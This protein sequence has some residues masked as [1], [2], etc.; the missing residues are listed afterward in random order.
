MGQARA[1]FAAEFRVDL[2]LRR[3]LGDLYRKERKDLE[4]LLSANADGVSAPGLAVLRQRS[5]RWAP[6]IK[7]LREAEAASRLTLPLTG[8]ASSLLHMHANRLLRSAARAQEMVL[9][10]F[11]AR[12]YES[13]SARSR[14]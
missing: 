5:K 6:A 2:N 3:Q 1:S 14:G 8:L 4:R 9:Y 11:L 12:L 7:A 10:D 13:R